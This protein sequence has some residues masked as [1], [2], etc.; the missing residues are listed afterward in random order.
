MS[1]LERAIAFE[2]AI[3]EAGI[4]RVVPFRYGHA[5]FVP[6]LPRVWDVNLVRV[7]G[8]THASAEEL[9]GEA[10]RLQGEAGLEHRRIAVLDDEAGRRL[11][12][13]FRAL[14]W[15]VNRFLFMAYRGNGT[16]P[17]DTS[18]VQEVERDAIRPVRAASVHDVPWG[19]DEDAVRQILAAGERYAAAVRP[20]YFAVL[21]EGRAVSVAELFSDGLTAQVE[22]VVTLPEARGR[23]YASATV[24]RAVDE[25]LAT[26]HDFVFLT[27]DE[28]DWP[29]EL[30]VRL[31]F[32][33]IGRKWTF[34]R[35]PARGDPGGTPP[36]GPAP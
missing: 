29:K 14:G 25:A 18:I 2:E 31:G 32:E 15:E 33:T 27:A 22:E 17:A 19:I 35:R 8:A 24:M 7:E 9:A 20:R 5:L 16:R 36:R 13:G 12:S 10:E 26:G 4:E 34:T 11:E 1:E 23:G 3:R 21:L 28:D 30:Y 6:S